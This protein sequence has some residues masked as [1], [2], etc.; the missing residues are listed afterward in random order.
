MEC[1]IDYAGKREAFG[2]PIAKLQAIQV[3]CINTN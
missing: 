2:S 1:A 3:R